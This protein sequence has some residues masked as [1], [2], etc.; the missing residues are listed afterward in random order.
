M[1]SPMLMFRTSPG[2]QAGAAARARTAVQSAGILT[3]AAETLHWKELCCGGLRE[4]CPFSFHTLGTSRASLLTS[5][6]GG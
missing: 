6:E 1:D 4:G 2:P 5:L 3:W